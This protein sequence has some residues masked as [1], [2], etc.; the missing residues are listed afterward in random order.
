[1]E[2]HHGDLIMYVQ[3]CSMTVYIL[4]SRASERQLA[5]EIKTVKRSRER[6]V[7]Y[8]IGRNTPVGVA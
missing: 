5:R 6:G 2:C 7:P 4:Y 3:V 8:A 1:M